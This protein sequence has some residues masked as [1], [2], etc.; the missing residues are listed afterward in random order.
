MPQRDQYSAIR[1]GVARGKL[2]FRRAVHHGKDLIFLPLELPDLFIKMPQRD[3]ERTEK[4][5]PD[6]AQVI[7]NVHLSGLD[8]F[9]KI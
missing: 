6:L 2:Q 7:L 1:C 9:L 8:P 3:R 5:T 4:G